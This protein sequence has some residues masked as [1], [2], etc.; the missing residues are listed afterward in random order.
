MKLTAYVHIAQ[1][2]R[3][4]EIAHELLDRIA[5][6]GLRDHLDHLNIGWSSPLPPPDWLHDHG[7]VCDHGADVLSGEVPTLRL[8][9]ADCQQD[10]DQYVC[11]IHVKGACHPPGNV[12]A[13]RD[14][15]ARGVVDRWQECVQALREGYDA[16]GNEWYGSDREAH[17]RGTWRL[18][19][20]DLMPHFAGNFWWAKGSY[21]S[22]L[23]NMPMTTRFDAEY[24]FVGTGE[25]RVWCPEF[26]GVDWYLSPQG[27][28]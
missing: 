13:W 2:G 18:H 25:P 28:G 24:R 8:L 27:S 21:I 26:R 5:S 16:A 6:T 3:W 17:W 1:L 10:P 9:Q 22:R 12:D 7:E 19:H 23:P 15:L 4:E 11:Y 14:H 20:L